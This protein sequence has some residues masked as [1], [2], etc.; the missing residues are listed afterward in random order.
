MMIVRVCVC[1]RESLGDRQGG[2][3]RE[4]KR[5]RE[6]ET[7][8]TPRVAA[9]R[10]NLYLYSHD[11]ATVHGE[12]ERDRLTDTRTLTRLT[13]SVQMLDWSP[14]VRRITSHEHSLPVHARAFPIFCG[15]PMTFRG[16]RYQED[17]NIGDQTSGERQR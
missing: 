15:L 3:E 7:P 2:R 12:Y 8:H 6:S 11:S 13:K 4:R 1:A 16:W 14:I 5:D 9:I 10:R 17:P